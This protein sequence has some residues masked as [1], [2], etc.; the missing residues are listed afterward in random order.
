MEKLTGEVV[1]DYIKQ[2][3]TALL[4][5]AREVYA[6]GANRAF[7]DAIDIGIRNTVSALYE[8]NV[9]DD[10]IT[11]LLNKYWGIPMNEAED[12]LL[13]EKYESVIRTLRH[14]LKMQGYSQSEIQHFMNTSRAKIKIRHDRELWKMKD[15]PEKLFNVIQK[16]WL[17]ETDN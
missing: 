12:R 9:S 17:D 10:K 11:H 3:G 8:A 14:Y 5:V 6:D 1:A 16:D 13:V 4:D 2:G 15:N 7:E